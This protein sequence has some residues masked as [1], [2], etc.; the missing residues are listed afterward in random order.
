MLPMCSA[1]PPMTCTSKCRWPRVRRAASRPTANASTR[2]SSTVSPSASRWRKTS[3]SWRSSASVILR[4]SSSTP[5]T[6]SAMDFSRRRVLPSPARRS[7]CRTT[8]VHLFA[9]RPSHRRRESGGGAGTGPGRLPRVDPTEITAGRLHLRPWQEGDQEALVAAGNDPESA[10]WTNVPSPYTRESADEW[11]RVT[12]PR[13]WAEGTA[14]SFAVCDSTT[15]EVLASVA[16]RQA[17]D[18]DVWSVGYWCVPEHRG[19]GVVPDALAPLCRW[20]FGALGAQRVEWMAQVGNYASLR[21]A[22]KA[23]FQVEGVLR[24]GLVHRGEHVDG[25]IAGLL[26]EDAQEDTGRFP[27][28]DDRTDGVV[29]VRRW[30]SSDA[31]DVVRAC[32]DPE[33]SR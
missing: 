4:K 12:A 30:R 28:Y 23:G 1:A 20:G 14:L 32:A 15:S 7:F 21:S 13:G 26:P 19:Q 5:L 22:Q 17:G 18:P 3:V 24:D 25:W 2:M 29:T 9:G 33:I 11:V 6:A 8:R 31:P 10:R 16:L 27:P